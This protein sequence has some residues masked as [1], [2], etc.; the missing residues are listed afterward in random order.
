MKDKDFERIAD[1]AFERSMVQYNKDIDID[2]SQHISYEDFYK[3]LNTRMEAMR[4]HMERYTAELI[5]RS[6]SYRPED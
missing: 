6:L 4:A 3:Y 1:E 5:R 2:T